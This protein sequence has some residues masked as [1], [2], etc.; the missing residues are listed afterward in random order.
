LKGPVGYFLIVIC[1][2]IAG[3]IIMFTDLSSGGKWF[4]KGLLGA[5]IIVGVL[6][7]VNQFFPGISGAI[8]I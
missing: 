7:I 6:T 2:V 3:A 1:I 4:I 8:I 5:S